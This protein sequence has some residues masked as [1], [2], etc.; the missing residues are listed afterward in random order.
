MVGCL[1]LAQIVC[2]TLDKGLSPLGLLIFLCKESVG[3][4]LYALFCLNTYKN[5]LNCMGNVTF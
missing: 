5:T 1:V 4:I 3:E 2:M